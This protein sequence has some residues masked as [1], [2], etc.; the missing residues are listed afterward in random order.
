MPLHRMRMGLHFMH[1]GMQFPPSIEEDREHI[2]Y[3]PIQKHNMPER[4]WGK[5]EWSNPRYQDDDNQ[6]HAKSGTLHASAM[7]EEGIKV[8]P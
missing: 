3:G 1:L 6:G 8:I 5:R 4:G 2:P 7:L